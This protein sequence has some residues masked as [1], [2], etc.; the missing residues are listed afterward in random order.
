M[1]TTQSSRKEYALRKQKSSS[2]KSGKKKDGTL[3]QKIE[4]FFQNSPTIIHSKGLYRINKAYS[5]LSEHCRMAFF[6]YKLIV[7]VP[8]DSSTL[9]SSF[10]SEVR[11]WT[12]T[13]SAESCKVEK[14]VLIEGPHS[15]K[16]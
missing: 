12:E 13:C 7:Y 2:N 15:S 14:A 16:V 9:S 11:V 5:M 8:K 1:S 3:Q 10:I 4:D 6:Y